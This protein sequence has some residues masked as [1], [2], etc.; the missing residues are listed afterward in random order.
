MAASSAACAALETPG[1]IH[2]LV[3][4][5]AFVR[6]HATSPWLKPVMN[7]LFGSRLW[8]PRP[9]TLHLSSLYP[10]RTPT[11]FGA[12]RAQLTA[13]LGEPGRIDALRRC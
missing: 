4:I 1:L 5:G 3:L 2:R 13:N 8:G 10:S 12:Y 6:V 9:W 7:V 11:D